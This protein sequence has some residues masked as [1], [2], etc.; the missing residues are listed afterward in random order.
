MKTSLCKLLS[1]KQPEIQ[2]VT[3]LIFETV[4]PE[5]IIRFSHTLGRKY[6]QETTSHSCNMYQIDNL[7]T[8]K[9]V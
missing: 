5:K 4:S 3:Q 7:L 6:Y 9:E 2:R 8:E 1:N